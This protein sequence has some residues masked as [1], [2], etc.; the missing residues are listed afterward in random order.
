ML[1]ILLCAQR[2]TDDNNRMP[3]MK[4]NRID[5]R[6]RIARF[7]GL[8]LIFLLVNVFQ[9]PASLTAGPVLNE[10]ASFSQEQKT[11]FS[12]TVVDENLVAVAAARVV[13]VQ[14]N[15]QAVS[16]GETD[17][18]GRYELA[19][20]EPG[21][22]QLRVEKEGF[23]AAIIDEVQASDAGTL[24][25]TLH[26]VQEFSEVMDVVSSTPAIDRT[27]SAAADG[28]SGQELLTIPYPTSRDIRNALPFIPGVV[29]DP[30]GQL[31]VNGSASNE[32]FNRLDGFNMSH[33]VN[34]AFDLRVSP[35]AVRSAE[36]Q[37]SRY[38]AEYGKGSGGV[39]SLTTGMGDDRYR[40]SA[41]NF[42]PSLQNRRGLHLD[43]W[44]PRATVSGPIIK[45]RAWF[46]DAGEAE[47]NLDIVNELPAGADRNSSWRF[48]NLA[49]TQVNLTQ[50]NI[51]SAS[52][53]VNRFHSDH[54]GLSRF[55]QIE[56]TLSLTDSAYL[57]TLK[58]QSYLANGILLEVGLGINQF[59]TGERPLGILPYELRPGSVRGSFFRTSDSR[60]VRTQFIASAIFPGFDWH[61]RHEIKAG[62]DVDRITYDQFFSRRPISIIRQD[63]TLSRQIMFSDGPG[64]RRNNVELSGFAQDRWSISDRL[65]LEVGLRSDWDEIVRRVSLSP[66]SALTYLVTADGQT[67]LSAGFGIVHDNS[68]LDFVTRPLAGQRVDFVYAEDGRTLAIPPVN[69]SFI[70]N[71]RDLRSPRFFNWSVGIER[72]L[73]ASVYLRTEFLQKRGSDGFAFV[74]VGSNTPAHPAGLFELRNNRRDRYDALEVTVRKAFK[75][76]YSFFAAYTRSATRSN[77]VIDFSLDSAAVSEQVGGR[78]AW[79]SP[80]RFIAWGSMPLIRHFDLACSVEWRDGFPFSVFNSDQQ[81][82]EAP[83]SRRLPFVF[84]LNAHVERRLRILGYRWALRAGFNN[85]TNRENPTGVDSNITS[86]QFLTFGGLQHRSFIGRIRF[87]GSK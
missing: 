3:K 38:S 46:F 5:L 63:E 25:V 79:D 78:M 53:L 31:H 49:K 61:G 66:R 15:T 17:Y 16:R 10:R 67:K 82:V 35:D 77:S 83:N 47:Y 28:L 9:S 19:G 60:A 12:L 4:G 48:S 54:S 50:S 70:V 41:T 75:E 40:F 72:R 6:I 85:L 30:T 51:L 14:R 44:T 29:Q 62:V 8:L 69:I 34:G 58:D 74:N 52:L 21:A 71:E 26:H 73:P 76:S 36:V 27:R 32:I 18:L 56:S 68:S 1:L 65:L 11:K 84:L 87:L 2:K 37:G 33:P 24:E 22:Y 55:N 20:V 86:P 45:K 64:F 80:N 7:A 23:Y 39:L 43:N 57:L 59:R 13:L 81:I 42:V